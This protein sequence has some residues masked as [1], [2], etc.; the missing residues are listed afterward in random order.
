M[1]L[2]EVQAEWIADLL[3]GKA[4]LPDRD[5][6][7]QQ[8]RAYRA[9]IRR[10]YVESKR[11]TIQVDFYPYKNAVE[12]ERVRGRSRSPEQALPQRPAAVPA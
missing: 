12:R 4:G 10:R 1:P 3:E 7:W 8:I 2:A 5:E 11:H 6:M 9:R